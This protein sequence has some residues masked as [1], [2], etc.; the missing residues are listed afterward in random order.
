MWRTAFD[1]NEGRRRS[2]RSATRIQQVRVPLRSRSRNPIRQCKDSAS[3]RSFRFFRHALTRARAHCLQSRARCR[4]GFG[5]PSSGPVHMHLFMAHCL[6]C[7]TGLNSYN[8]LSRLRQ[9]WTLARPYQPGRLEPADVGP[10]DRAFELA[11]DEI[12]GG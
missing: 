1:R 12:L 7:F 4:T 9:D 11:R 6:R 2:S 5:Q 3:L 10:P 8:S